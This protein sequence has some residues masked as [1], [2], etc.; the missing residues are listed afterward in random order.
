MSSVASGVPRFQR[1]E[2][3]MYYR[4]TAIRAFAV[5][6]TGINRMKKSHILAIVGLVLASS[7]SLSEEKKGPHDNA[8]EAR[9]GLMQVRGFYMGILSAMAKGKMDY[10]ADL[11]ALS[12]TSLHAASAMNTSPMW[13]AGSDD[14]N[15]DNAE[16][17]ALVAIWDTYPDVAEK[18]KK[19]VAATEALLPVAGAG[20]DALKGS[21]GNVGK[22]CKGCHD[23][24][25]AE[26][27]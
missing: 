11:A 14:S 6:Q 5:C 12:A 22:A 9:Q 18:G 7:A 4:A 10:D 26:K 23:D 15:P 8:I 13:P 25:R 20:L 21:I 16:N 17:R 24:F 3:L 27:K 19:L 1:I 2:T